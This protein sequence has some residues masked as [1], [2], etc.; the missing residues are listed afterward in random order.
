MDS[1]RV[2]LIATACRVRANLSE[3]VFHFYRSLGFPLQCTQPP[4]LVAIFLAVEVSYEHISIF[5]GSNY[6]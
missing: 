3:H 2:A 1:L 6:F 4:N 5:G